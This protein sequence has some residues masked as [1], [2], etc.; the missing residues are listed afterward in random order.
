MKKIF[1]KII[2]LLL[3]FLLLTLDYAVVLP[4]GGTVNPLGFQRTVFSPFR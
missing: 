2:M 3:F 4:I 1:I